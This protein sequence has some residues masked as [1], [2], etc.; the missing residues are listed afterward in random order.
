MPDTIVVSQTTFGARKHLQTQSFGRFAFIAG[1]ILFMAPLLAL[2]LV[3]LPELLDPGTVEG[4]AW[5]HISFWGAVA[6]LSL[7]AVRVAVLG[8]QLLFT[9][10]TKL[11]ATW[12][13]SPYPPPFRS[14]SR[15]VHGLTHGELQQVIQDDWPTRFLR[16]LSPGYVFAPPWVRDAASSA[17]RAGVNTAIAG[18]IIGAALVIGKVILSSEG[19]LESVSENNAPLA[20]ALEGLGDRLPVGAAVALVLAGL[21]IAAASTTLLQQVAAPD[22]SMS[23]QGQRVKG[24]LTPEDMP[25]MLKRVLDDEAWRGQPRSRVDVNGLITA[26]GGVRD[27]GPVRGTVLFEGHV[28]AADGAAQSPWFA[29]GATG[30]VAIVAAL[31]LLF[32]GAPSPG[33]GQLAFP[34][35]AAKPEYFIGGPFFPTAIWVACMWAVVGHGKMLLGR[36]QRLSE[37][38]RYESDVI[39]IEASGSYSRSEINVGKAMSDSI[40]SRN[41]A[42]RSDLTLTYWGARACSEEFRPGNEREVISLHQDEGVDAAVYALVEFLQVEQSAG[43]TPLQ[44]D[45]TAEAMQQLVDVNVQIEVAKQ[46]AIV[47]SG[48]YIDRVLADA[49][50]APQLPAAGVPAAPGRPPADVSGVPSHLRSAADAAAPDGVSDAL[51]ARITRLNNLHTAGL[52]SDEEFQAKRRELLAEL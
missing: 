49:A 50:D 1:C 14:Q 15:L 30:V 7:V 21:L 51:T 25:Q 22:I 5:T 41:L 8:F 26:G 36:S 29:P 35:A 27:A 37:I 34:G 44:P 32:I 18:V 45:L 46:R 28:R 4:E 42:V 40:E 20:I 47:A 43:F 48:G 17:L 39:F 16:S 24:A 19:L 12:A 10:A 3:I 13:P 2:V 6:M 11:A 52:I 31:L 9:G 33:L 23:R 38:Y